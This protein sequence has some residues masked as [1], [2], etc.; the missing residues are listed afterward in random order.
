VVLG[1]ATLLGGSAGIMSGTLIG[2]AQAVAAGAVIAVLSISIIPY[3]F[4]EVSSRVALATTL[5]FTA[6]YL[7]S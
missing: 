2:V 4:E 6:G 7:L 3:T 5:G 1:L